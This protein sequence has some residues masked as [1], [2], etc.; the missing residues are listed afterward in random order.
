MVSKGW[1][2]QM[3]ATARI[4]NHIHSER[5]SPD[6]QLCNAREDAG[7]ETLP[8]AAVSRGDDFLAVILVDASRRELRRKLH[9][10]ESPK[11]PS[12]STILMMVKSCMASLEQ[13]ARISVEVTGPS[14]TTA[15]MLI[16]TGPIDT[17]LIQIHDII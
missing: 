2:W 8:L 13:F 5:D 11:V 16:A 12:F 14:C 3:S 15:S 17:H 10:H 4:L 6:T 1:L 7:D 9:R